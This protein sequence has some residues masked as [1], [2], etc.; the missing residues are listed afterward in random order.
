MKEQINPRE[1][2]KVIEKNEE[3]DRAELWKMME[4]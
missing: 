3:E 1:G 2:I 4:N